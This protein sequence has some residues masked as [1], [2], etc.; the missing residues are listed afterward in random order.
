MNGNATTYTAT[1]RPPYELWAALTWLVI[2]PLWV[3]LAVKGVIVELVAWAGGAI[4]GAYAVHR[5]LQGFRVLR[6]RMRLRGYPLMF[7]RSAELRAWMAHH[8]NRVYLGRGFRW[9]QE[10]AQRAYEVILNESLALDGHRAEGGSKWLHGV[11]ERETDITISRNDLVGHLLLVG[12][13]RS[14]KTVGLRMLIAQAVMRGE[15]VIVIDPK[16]D[17]ELLNVTREACLLAGR[18]QDFL[19]FHPAFPSE[20]VRL[21]PLR[22]FSRPTELAAR[23]AALIP[24][25][26]GND[27]F[28]AYGQMAMN[29]IVHGLLLAHRKPTLK[30]LRRY[31]E[32]GPEEAVIQAAEAWFDHCG[33]PDWR[34]ALTAYRSAARS[35]DLNARAMAYVQYY[36]DHVAP[37]MPSQDMEGLIGIYLHNREHFAKMIASLLP[38]LN[39]LTSGTLGELLSPDH[40]NLNDTRPICDFRRIIERAQVLYVGLDALSDP[41]SARYIGSLLL[42]DLASVAGDRYNYGNLDGPRVSVVIDEAAECLHDPFIAL[43]NKGGGAGFTLTVA[44]QTLGDWEAR[45]GSE[46]KARMVLGNLNTIIALRTIDLKTAKY[47]AESLPETTVRSVEH[48][49]SASGETDEPHHFRGTINESLRERTIPLITP[50]QLSGLPNCEYVIRMRDGTVWK[51]RMPILIAKPS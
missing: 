14:G 46:A 42:A 19:W 33:I 11:G 50:Q 51:G 27:P 31:V 32:V 5:G 47:I 34:K 15:P 20:S 38:V 21:D 16:G 23:I 26:G 35:H 40:R 43:L 1:Y 3:L 44:T 22:N 41:F 9:G 13:T 17:R 48:S 29:A 28:A 8:E 45:L 7:M 6:R 18:E 37:T 2:V 25:Q 24:A 4:Y 12:T 30:E 10:E 49:Q 36:Q 39:V